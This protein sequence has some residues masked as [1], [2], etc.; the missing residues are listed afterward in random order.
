[1]GVD[2]KMQALNVAV[3]EAVPHM[4]RVADEN[5]NAQVLVRTIKFSSGAQWQLAQPTPVADFR[6]DDLQ[7]DG[8][9]D[10]GH[11]L[12]MVAD[13]LCPLTSTACLH[14]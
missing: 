2:G 3:R 1:M 7:S 11:A 4:Q 14:A 10:L 6:W 9:T 13:E 12:R 5:P 8:V